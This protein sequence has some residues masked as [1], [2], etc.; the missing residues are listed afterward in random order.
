MIKN[1]YAI[2]KIDFT[3][4]E[5]LITIAIIGIVAIIV[6]PILKKYQISTLKNG[7]KEGYAIMAQVV[8]RMEQ[9]NYDFYSVCNSSQKGEE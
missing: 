9:D 2:K 7:F 6:I 8:Y 1:K 4:A 3:L 5:V